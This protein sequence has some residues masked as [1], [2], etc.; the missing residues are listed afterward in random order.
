MKQLLDCKWNKKWK[1]LFGN[2]LKTL[3]K[4]LYFFSNINEVHI[5]HT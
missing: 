1:S 4:L 5:K 2:I 3:Q